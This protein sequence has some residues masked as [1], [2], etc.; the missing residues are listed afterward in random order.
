M[1]IIVAGAGIAG[2]TAALAFAARGFPVRL[3]ERAAAIEE[4]GAGIQLSPNA[5]RILDRLGVLPALLRAATRPQAVVIRD[6]RSLRQLASVPLGDFA[7]QRWGAPY[8]VLHRNDLQAALLAHARGQPDIEIVT[9]ATVRGARFGGGGS[10]VS[11]ERDGRVETMRCDLIVGADGVRS[12]LRAGWNGSASR[13]TGSI[14][15]RA[16]LPAG[17]AHHIALDAVTTFVARDFHLVAYPVQAGGAINL[18]VVTKGSA[19]S[20]SESGTRVLR[21][22]IRTA[23]P[24]L[25]ELVE[26][27][28]WTAWQI[29][30]VNLATAWTDPAGLALIGD[31]A[32]AMT[33]FA[34]Q[35]AA[36]AIEDAVTLA[37]AVARS[38]D[39][40]TDAFQLYETLRRKRVGWVARRGAF[41]HFAWHAS[42]PVALARNLLL[43]LRPPERLAAD[44][45]WIYGWDL[46]AEM[47]RIG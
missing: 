6:G 1:Q 20:G 21:S 9:G 32:H 19:A 39:D 25:T 4:A 11:I 5:T 45:D 8:L 13:D 14:A 2:L 27:G 47:Q 28:R 44:L 16:T 36:M 41:N 34:A 24:L 3:F 18:V 37:A 40:L 26:T 7:R 42:G 23:A 15:W 35:G 46:E 10:S 12:A 31:A 29:H 43:L 22:A 17:M 33:P 30:E 38:P